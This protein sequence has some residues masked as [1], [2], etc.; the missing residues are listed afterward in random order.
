MRQV[1]DIS[2]NPIGP[3]GGPRLEGHWAPAATRG[4]EAPPDD[5]PPCSETLMLIRATPPAYQG[6]LDP[7]PACHEL[8]PTAAA[9][10]GGRAGGE[11][12]WEGGGLCGLEQVVLVDIG[13]TVLPSWVFNT[14]GLLQLSFGAN[15]RIARL[16]DELSLLR[17]LRLLSC[18]ACGMEGC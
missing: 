11:G 17:R 5:A 3:R 7:V 18:S 4:R 16:P 6:G 10:A 12:K 2:M 13:L 9:M 1:L 15:R 14:M 8:E